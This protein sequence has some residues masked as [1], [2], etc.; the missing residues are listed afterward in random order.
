MSIWTGTFNT[1]LLLTVFLAA[2]LAL[3]PISAQ[4]REEQEKSRGSTVS[5]DT[6]GS[7][8]HDRDILLRLHIGSGIGGLK[9]RPLHGD[10]ELEFEIGAPLL[11]NLQIGATIIENF[12]IYGG[13]SSLTAKD[14]ELFVLAIGASYYVMPFNLYIS[15]EYRFN[16][17]AVGYDDDDRQFYNYGREFYYHRNRGWGVTIGKE[18]WVAADLG[19]GLALTAYWDQLEGDTLE[20]GSDDVKIALENGDSAESR[21]IGIALSVTYN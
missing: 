20:S 1:T 16:G 2:L 18:W 10:E 17:W 3:F 9:N 6:S 4:N 21:Y 12:A 7:E 8:R 13:L 11:F 5:V 14:Y 19:I 15:S